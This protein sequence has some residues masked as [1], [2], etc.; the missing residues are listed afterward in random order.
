MKVELELELSVGRKSMRRRNRL[1]GWSERTVQTRKCMLRACVWT[2]GGSWD[3]Y[4]SLVEFPYNNSFHATIGMPP[5]EKL[6]GRRCRTLIF[7][8][9]VGQ[10][11]LGSN[12]IIQ[13]AAESISV[14]S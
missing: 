8:G 11:E 12:K 6:C 2:F 10:S 7:W 4:L 5:Y 1:Q 9:E 14:E 13:K 3:T